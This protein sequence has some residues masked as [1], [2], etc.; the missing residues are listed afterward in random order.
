[1]NRNKN[2]DDEDESGEDGDESGED[3]AAIEGDDENEYVNENG[4]RAAERTFPSL[5]RSSRK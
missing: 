5:R 2:M 4:K 1:M 3:A